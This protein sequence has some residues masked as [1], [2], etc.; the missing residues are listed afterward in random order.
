M[1]TPGVSELLTWHGHDRGG[2]RVPFHATMGNPLR[3]VLD[4]Y[5]IKKLKRL[6][7]DLINGTPETPAGFF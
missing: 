3:T 5:L 4:T 1:K 7:F 2:V 6:A